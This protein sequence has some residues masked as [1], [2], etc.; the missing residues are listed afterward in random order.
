MRHGAIYRAAS[1]TCLIAKVSKTAN[2]WERM[3]GLLGR[4]PLLPE[5]GLLIEPCPSVHTLGM[6]Y[7]IDIVF[8][9]ANYRVLRQ[10]AQLKPLRWAACAGARATLELAPGSLSTLNLTVGERLEWRVV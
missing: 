1:D 3:R 10:V 4:P 6:R 8:L 7:P 2:T 9:D 5:Q